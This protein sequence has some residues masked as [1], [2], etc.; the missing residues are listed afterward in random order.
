[1]LYC[2]TEHDEQEQANTEGGRTEPQNAEEKAAG[3]R[4]LKRR[5]TRLTGSSKRCVASFEWR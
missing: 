4:R 2:V 5:S 3:F 1:M